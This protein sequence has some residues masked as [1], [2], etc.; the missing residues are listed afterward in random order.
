MQL[1]Q[2][3]FNQWIRR[4]RVVIRTIRVII[5]IIVEVRVVLIVVETRVG[6]RREVIRSEVAVDD[7]LVEL[8]F[9]AAFE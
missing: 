1:L 2:L 7:L 6:E 5:I 8:L 4:V 3:L 9:L